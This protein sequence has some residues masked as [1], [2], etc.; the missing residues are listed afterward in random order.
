MHKVF[1]DILVS[2]RSVSDI[3]YLSIQEKFNI[4]FWI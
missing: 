1:L 2:I 4:N 3:S